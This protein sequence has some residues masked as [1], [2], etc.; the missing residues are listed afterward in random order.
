MEK[1]FISASSTRG[2]VGLTVISPLQLPIKRQM[3]ASAKEVYAL[4]D[5]SKFHSMG[6]SLFADFK[7][8]SGIIT[9]KSI[10]DPE[11]LQ[12]L[13]EQ[14]VQVICTEDPEK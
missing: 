6:V 8:L 2:T 9:S 10:D 5:E 11:L 12:R 4:L 13:E 3:V 14:N 1:A 7:D